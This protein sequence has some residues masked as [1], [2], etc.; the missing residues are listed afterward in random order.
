[1][2]ELNG[3]SITQERFE[4]LLAAIEFRD[5]KRRELMPTEQEALALMFEAF[6]RL[7]ELGWTEAAY[8]PADRRTI[9]LIEAGSTGIHSGYCEER[10][11]SEFRTKWF[12]I[13]DNDMWPSKPILYREAKPK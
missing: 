8:A 9:E 1:M 3:E 11:A 13:V 12:W 5:Q 7:K 6:Q 4:A 2:S 10:P